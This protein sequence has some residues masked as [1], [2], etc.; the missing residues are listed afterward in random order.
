MIGAPFSSFG[1]SAALAF[2][3]AVKACS[4][5]LCAVVGVHV[6]AGVATSV[7]F[8]DSNS[9]FE[10]VRRALVE[11]GRVV[12]GRIAAHEDHL[13]LC[14][15][16][17]GDAADQALGHDLADRD[18]VERHVVRTAAA[19]RQ[20]VVVD[21]LDAVGLRVALDLGAGAR[22]LGV[23]QDD[24]RAVGDVA[25]GVGVE[26]RVRPA[27]VLDDDVRARDAC[28]LQRLLQVRLVE[29]DIAGRAGGVRED[30]GDLPLAALAE[31]LQH[32]QRRER[33]VERAGRDRRRPARRARTGTRS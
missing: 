14:H 24:R 8:F 13:R 3:W 11:Q 16:P 2:E 19:E 9:G 15:A 1:I 7:H 28:C 33:V 23:R 18:V 10:H 4:N 26:R 20:P 30:R 22:V 31:R 12:V 6:P 25:L 32:V 17:G 29:L 27:G 21:H 5:S